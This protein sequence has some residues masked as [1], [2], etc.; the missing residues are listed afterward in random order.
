MKGWEVRFHRRC[1]EW[2]ERSSPYLVNDKGE[3]VAGFMRQRV[4]HPGQED[5][6]AIAEAYLI[7]N[8]VNAKLEAE[9]TKP[10]CLEAMKP[11]EY[12]KVIRLYDKDGN[13]ILSVTR[14]FDFS[15]DFDLSTPD[16]HVICCAPVTDYWMVVLAEHFPIEDARPVDKED[17]NE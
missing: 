8:A 16:G 12:G 3:D 6:E 4:N 13:H 17:D 2:H 1:P 15:E 7:R 14:C 11:L 10:E 5:K 9:E